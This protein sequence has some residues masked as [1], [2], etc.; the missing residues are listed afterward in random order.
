MSGLSAMPAPPAAAAGGCDLTAY[1]GTWTGTWTEFVDGSVF[2]SGT[3]SLSLSVSPDGNVVGHRQPGWALYGSGFPAVTDFQGLATCEG[4][5][6]TTNVAPPPIEVYPSY[7]GSAAHLTGTQ[8][9]LPP[10]STIFFVEDL[11]RVGAGPAVDLSALRPATVG[12]AYSAAAA[13]SGSI[14]PGTWV[15]DAGSLP[16]GLTFSAA[17][18]LSGTPKVVGTFPIRVRV[19]FDLGGGNTEYRWA[20]LSFRVLEQPVIAPPSLARGVAGEW[21]AAPLTASGGAE[22]FTWALST[23][24]LPPGLEFAGGVVSGVPSAVGSWPI[25]VKA[26]S[27][28]GAVASRRYVIKVTRPSVSVQLGSWVPTGQVGEEYLSQLTS[29]GGVAPWSWQVKSGSLPPGLS[30]DPAG[31]VSGVPLEAGRWKVTIEVA[32]STAPKAVTR[33]EKVEFDIRPAA[34]VIGPPVLPPAAVKAAYPV[35]LTASGGTAPYRYELGLAPLPPGLKL[36]KAGK[37]S[38]KPTTTGE[39]TVSVT[40][41]DKYGYTGSA[42]YTITVT[43]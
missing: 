16:K 31:A 38:G 28:E 21:Y 12:T 11:V 29:V 2:N 36:S 25:T 3:F 24:A 27:A 42:T 39:W 22:P 13:A 35:Q 43:F 34:I 40:A 9:L 32:D 26:T 8:L 23:G 4:L 33:S 15:I 10:V 18:V 19:L 37:I 1:S 6:V 7:Q 14:V 5:A 20:E 41:T 30:L 17:G